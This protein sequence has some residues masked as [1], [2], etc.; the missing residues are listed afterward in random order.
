MKKNALLIMIL[1]FLVGC[2]A[3]YNITINEDLTVDESIVG[4]ENNEFYERYYNSSK[5]RVINFVISLK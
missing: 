2:E 4:L 5:E 3:R 1:L